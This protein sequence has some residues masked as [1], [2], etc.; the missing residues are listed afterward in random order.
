MSRLKG[1]KDR[2]EQAGELRRTLKEKEEES[3]SL[4]EQLVEKEAEAEKH[5]RAAHDLKREVC[6]G[7]DGIP[8][9]LT[10]TDS[11]FCG[12]ARMTCVVTRGAVQVD[13]LKKSLN[14]LQTSAAVGEG[15]RGG[16]GG[17]EALGGVDLEQKCQDLWA[18]LQDSQSELRLPDFL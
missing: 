7:L 3:E 11:G 16:T 1:Y 9:L 18:Q 2:L 14:L 6:V 5:K 8:T 10:G 12:W 13:A 4:I 17:P 15:Q